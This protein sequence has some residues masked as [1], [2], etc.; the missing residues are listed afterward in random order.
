MGVLDPYRPRS[1]APT[2]LLASLPTIAFLATAFH[3]TAIAFLANSY[4]HLCITIHMLRSCQATALLSIMH[5][6]CVCNLL[7]SGSM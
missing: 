1:L 7:Q 4:L 3:T 5:V 6:Y 2:R